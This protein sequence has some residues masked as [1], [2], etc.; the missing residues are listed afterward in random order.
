MCFGEI[1]L[2][3]QICTFLDLECLVMQKEIPT[4]HVEPKCSMYSGAL[5]TG[6]R[7]TSMPSRQAHGEVLVFQR[8]Q[9]GDLCG[10][11]PLH[12]KGRHRCIHGRE[13]AVCSIGLGQAPGM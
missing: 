11:N 13:P 2:G 3:C 12:P 10:K 4:K 6:A 8:P 7:W 1:C 9:V 5:G